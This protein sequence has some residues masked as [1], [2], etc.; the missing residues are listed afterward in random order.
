[1]NFRVR[2]N[3]KDRDV[4]V[5][6]DM[7][8]LWVLRDVLGLTGTKY[9]CGIAQCGACTVH[10]GKRAIRSC[11]LPISSVG[12]AEVTTIEAVGET[13]TGAAAQQAWLQL[14]VVQCGYCQSG[15]IMS[16][17]A[18]IAKNPKPT[19]ADIDAAMSGNICRCA[20]YP[21]IRAAIK[22]AAAGVHNT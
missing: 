4:D 14:E 6:P 2:V 7:P 11:V 20:T 13:P 19:D 1:M 16:A 22:Q 8:L 21:R 5:P 3:G 10:L 17:A 9:G 15:Q 12:S 18:L